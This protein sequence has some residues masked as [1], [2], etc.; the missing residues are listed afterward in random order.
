MTLRSRLVATLCA[1]VMATPLAAQDRV[2]ELMG[3]CF[4][5]S[6]TVGQAATALSTIGWAV[7]GD[8]ERAVEARAMT[9]PY[10][11]GRD[12]QDLRRKGVE[13][14]KEEGLAQ[15]A[16][17]ATMS[18]FLTAPEGHTLMMTHT[19]DAMNCT[20][21]IAEDVHAVAILNLLPEDTEEGN[22]PQMEWTHFVPAPPP[23]GVSGARGTFWIADSRDYTNI[24]PPR[25]RDVK[26]IITTQ[27]RLQ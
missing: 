6:G 12:E 2:Q 16:E 4:S 1:T 26:M 3:A 24:N 21:A 18:L 25:P 10:L 9:I 11:S 7:G 23:P 5:Q 15:A 19:G 14:Y 27:V 17:E 8:Y 22:D 20:L 13:Y